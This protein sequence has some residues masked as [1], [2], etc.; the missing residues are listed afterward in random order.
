MAEKHTDCPCKNR[1]CYRHRD[2]EPCKEYHHGRK[3][4]TACE[5]LQSDLSRTQAMKIS[6]QTGVWTAQA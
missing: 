6:S 3:S 4:M 5:R 1:D 2:C